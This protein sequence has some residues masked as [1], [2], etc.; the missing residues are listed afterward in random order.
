MCG[1]R[2]R[3]RII[4]KIRGHNQSGGQILA[5][6][7]RRVDRNLESQQRPR[8][9]WQT[10]PETAAH[11][12]PP[13]PHP[14][15]AQLCP[16]I[17]AQAKSTSSACNLL[18]FRA[19]RP[20]TRSP[21]H[22]HAHLCPRLSTIHRCAEIRP[23]SYKSLTGCGRSFVRGSSGDFSSLVPPS[24]CLSG[25][26]RYYF[27]TADD[28]LPPNLPRHHNFRSTIDFLL[29]CQTTSQPPH[30]HTKNGSSR[31]A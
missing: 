16:A 18:S 25:S 11:P 10:V 13:P 20:R 6:V 17:A 22:A 29:F 5:A 9:S 7:A 28:F 23:A 26:P 3:G 2:Q 14:R 12:T 19:F 4:N 1:L 27:S 24:V 31:G 30:H 8:N 15:R 21:A